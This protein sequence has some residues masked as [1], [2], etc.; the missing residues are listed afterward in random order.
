MVS[1]IQTKD[2]DTGIYFYTIIGEGNIHNVKGF[3]LGLNYVQTVIEKHGGTIEVK[4]EINK[5]STFEMFI[6]K[7]HG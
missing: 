5:G 2:L 7:T 3:G 4:S 6:P 1:I